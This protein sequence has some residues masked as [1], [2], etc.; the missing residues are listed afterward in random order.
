VPKVRE[1]ARDRFPDVVESLKE[2]WKARA[3]GID[4]L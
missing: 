4:A 2:E 3:A 1:A